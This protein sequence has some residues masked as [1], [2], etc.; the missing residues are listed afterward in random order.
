MKSEKAIKTKKLTE[1]HLRDICELLEINFISFESFSSTVKVYFEDE[2]IE[3]K[4]KCLSIN[5][6]GEILIIFFEIGKDNQAINTIP[7]VLYLLEH[8]LLFE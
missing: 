7:V 8:E 4:N 3:T 2:S 5:Q 6:G 1:E